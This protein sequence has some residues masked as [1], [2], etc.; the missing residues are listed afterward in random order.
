MPAAL[1]DL[2]D[3]SILG[4]QLGRVLLDGPLEFVHLLHAIAVAAAV[5]LQLSLCRR[6]LADIHLFRDLNQVRQLSVL[7]LH[8]RS[9]CL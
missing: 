9:T 2:R 1:L 4:L 3:V 7:S 8:L 5:V 6:I